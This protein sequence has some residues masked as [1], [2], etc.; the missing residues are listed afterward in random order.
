MITMVVVVIVKNSTPTL[1]N[2][3]PPLER[4]KTGTF[5]VSTSFCGRMISPRLASSPN[6]EAIEGKGGGEDLAGCGK[7]I[8]VRQNFTD[9]HIWNNGGTPR[10]MLRKSVQQGRRRI[11]TRGVPSGVR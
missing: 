4:R 3:P 11:E 5:Y 9:L 1:T 7:T 8:V 10:R 2:S 6:R